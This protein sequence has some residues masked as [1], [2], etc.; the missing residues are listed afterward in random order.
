[1]RAARSIAI[2]LLVVVAPITPALAQSDTPA[3]QCRSGPYQ[4]DGIEPWGRGILPSVKKQISALGLRI[5]LNNCDARIACGLEEGKDRAAGVARRTCEAVLR[6]LL[7]TQL[8]TFDD[9]RMAF[10]PNVEFGTVRVFLS[11]KG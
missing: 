7:R 8:S 10:P 2:A 11:P 5:A 9:V 4:F 6:I 3:D 1:M